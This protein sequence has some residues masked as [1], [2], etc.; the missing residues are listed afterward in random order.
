[1]E[2]KLPAFADVTIHH[3]RHMGGLET[4]VYFRHQRSEWTLLDKRVQIARLAPF[5]SFGNEHVGQC[6]SGRVFLEKTKRSRGRGKAS[7][8]V[9]YRGILPFDVIFRPEQRKTKRMNDTVRIVIQGAENADAVPGLD[10]LG[11]E[12]ELRF[13]T[14]VASL[15]TAL[16]GAEVLLGWNFRGGELTR[17]WDTA[18]R[19]R[20]IHWSGAGVDALLFPEL[21][22]NDVTVTNARGVFD[23]AMAEYVLGLVIAFAKHL[24][25]TLVLQSERKW[26]HRVTERIEGSKALVVGTGSIGREI[27]RLLS[28][29]GMAVTGVGRRER[30]DDP[31]FGTV[32][33]REDLDRLLPDANYIVNV[34]P[35]T[36]ENVAM[37]GATQFGAMKNTARFINVGRGTTVDEAA[38]VEALRAGDI[39]GAGLD[40]FETEPL[41][42]ESP[43]WELRNV[44][45]S[46]HMS[47]DFHG[48]PQVL[49][50]LFIDNLA[51]YRQG[52][53]LHNVVDKS[54]GYVRR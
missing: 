35:H 28:A 15:R 32:H 30:R 24:P 16:D 22:E 31:D 25:E 5:E 49:A 26:Q 34:V 27:A 53:P 4:T 21:V 51:R 3:D 42:P 48:Y 13:A 23:R 33:P 11:D 19:L 36:A 54:L 46:P 37:F 10:R 45:V 7:F 41:A 8:I 6:L 40:V 1:M 44:I 29:A 52:E 50:Q 18:N 9:R 12:V 47:G 43:L 20:W 2:A 17:A 14:D 38:L 39:A